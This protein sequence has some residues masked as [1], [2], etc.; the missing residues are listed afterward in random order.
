MILLSPVI[1]VD[2]SGR[3]TKIRNKLRSTERAEIERERGL[4]DARARG[5]GGL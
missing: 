4:D 3:K 5:A 2:P 1:L